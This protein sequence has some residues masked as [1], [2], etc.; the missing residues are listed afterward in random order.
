M[1]GHDDNLR[2]ANFKSYDVTVENCVTLDN[3][4]IG[5]EGVEFNVFSQ[6]LKGSTSALIESNN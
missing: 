3:N 2:S 6:A 4:F 1:F 5:G